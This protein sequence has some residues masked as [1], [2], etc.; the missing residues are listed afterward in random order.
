MVNDY[1]VIAQDTLLER[2]FNLSIT[3]LT[4][5][6]PV[7]KTVRGPGSLGGTSIATDRPINNKIFSLA[8][9]TEE[10]V[11]EF[12]AFERTDPES[13]D[14]PFNDRSFE[15]R[16]PDG[17]KHTL[18][19]LIEELEAEGSSEAQEEA[20]KL[21]SRFGQDDQGNYVVRTIEEQRIWLREYVHN[22][23]LS[24]SWSLFGPG[25]DF[26]RINGQ[27]E[28][29]GTPIFM[30]GA[31]LEPDPNTEKTGTGNI[32]FKVGGRL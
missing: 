6:I 11:I 15:I 28:P 19:T 7:F 4:Y 27:G 5:V 20:D 26:R 8:G 21:K 2:R 29:Q 31:D 18:D 32:D 24:A 25:Y 30:E 23:G 3:G 16:A 12:E 22:P 1:K 14:S 9:K 10:G 17:E 13:I